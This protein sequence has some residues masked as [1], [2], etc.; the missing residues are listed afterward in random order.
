MFSDIA[1]SKTYLTPNEVAKVLMVSPVTIRTWAQKGLIDAKL[2]PGG[3]RRF[4]KADVERFINESE[5]VKARTTRVLII[6]NDPLMTDYVNNIL[7]TS[8]L[9][10]ETDVATNVFEAGIKIHS[11]SPD[12]ILLNCTQSEREGCEVCALIKNEIA[13]RHISVIALT[14]DI[15][16]EK[17]NQILE[18]GAQTCL[19]KPF[20]SDKL[21]ETLC[22]FSSMKKTLPSAPP[23]NTQDSQRLSDELVNPE[24]LLA[25]LSHIAQVKNK[26][27]GHSDPKRLTNMVDT[28]ARSLGHLDS[29]DL[30]VLKNACMLHDIGNLGIPD[31]I[32]LK[33]DALTEKERNI[34]HG[35]TLIGAQLCSH[36]Q[37]MTLTIPIIR[38]HHERWDGSGYPDGLAGEAIPFLARVFQFLDIFDSLSS[39]KPYRHALSFEE[40]V[41]IIRQEIANHW[42][43]PVLGA[44]FLNLLKKHPQQFKLPDKAGDTS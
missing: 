34:L 19:S 12:V 18:S 43:D 27:V 6:D 17:V 40:T 41:A 39:P 20:S 24:M 1:P 9:D 14:E 21:I 32:L 28:F 22:R 30:K 8:L 42:L 5:V 37:N 13:I 31:S 16:P 35:H 38:S 36:L 4:L 2:T 33:S 7:Q 10:F 11:F 29:D 25:S 44:K 3:H 23:R 26:Y 15:A